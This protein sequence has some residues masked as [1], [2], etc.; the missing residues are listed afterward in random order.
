MTRVWL[1]RAFSSVRAVLDLVRQGDQ[2]GEYQLVC[3][4]PRP[5]FPGF[6]SAHEH[7]IEPNGLDESEYVQFCLDFCCERSIDVLWPGQ[8]AQ[9][10]VAERERF[11]ELGV[12]VLAVASPETLD[13]LED[14]ARFY[15]EARRF[16]IPPPESL[17]FDTAADFEACYTQLRSDHDLLCIKPSVGI[18]G[19][20]FRII[21]E[22]R[23]SLEL[24]LQNAIH[25]IHLAG[26]QAALAAADR[27]QPMLLMEHLS[28]PEYSVD[29][30]ADGRRVL[31][32]VQRQKPAASAYGQ[33][34]VSIPAIEQAVREMTEA[35]GLCGLFNVQFR[36]GRD[37]IRLLEIN[38]RVSGG[39]GYT[40]V[41]GVNLPYLALKGWTQGFGALETTATQAGARVLELLHYQHGEDVA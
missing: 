7:A 4:H 1:N 19:A 2:A 34:L 18:N 6:L 12:R 33:L 29:C 32:L 9:A 10:I 17:T 26:L 23:G 11:A 28:G 21:D 14:K 22:H 3:S 30:V 8:S 37:G 24:L 31:A 39:I 36:E 41:A 38:A 15:A 13:L 35:F 40:G 20:G 27:F 16:S 5:S 25:S